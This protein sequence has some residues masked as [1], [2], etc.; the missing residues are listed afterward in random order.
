MGGH[1]P[2]D[3]S[4]T[5]HPLMHFVWQRTIAW[6]PGQQP[7]RYSAESSPGLRPKMQ[8]GRIVADALKP[9]WRLKPKIEPIG[10]VAAFEATG[11][12]ERGFRQ[13]LLEAGF[14]AKMFFVRF[15]A[16]KG[17]NG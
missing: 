3:R 9:L 4:P 1:A 7:S 12:Y 13:A 15:L 14:G 8:G 17:D 11:G 2:L 5:D 10:L 16:R 6:E